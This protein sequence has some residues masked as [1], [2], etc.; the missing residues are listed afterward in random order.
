[1]MAAT[2]D[3]ECRGTAFS[4]LPPDLRDE[5]HE[6]LNAWNKSNV[7]LGPDHP[8]TIELAERGNEL[9]RMMREFGYKG[10]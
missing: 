5:W 2:P 9:D 7:A 6:A 8:R 4:D 3:H 1:M 10:Q